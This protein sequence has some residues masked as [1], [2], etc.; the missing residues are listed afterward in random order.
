[1]P[2]IDLHKTARQ[3]CAVCSVLY[4]GLSSYLSKFP[5]GQESERSTDENANI[6]L[7]ATIPLGAG[8]SN[9]N[10]QAL[11]PSGHTICFDFFKTQDSGTS[12]FKL[13]SILILLQASCVFVSHQA[14]SSKDFK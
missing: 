12:T 2:L 14:L 9:Y 4:E 1:M 11:M 5:L 7:G 8:I 13:Y 3:G 6:I 10:Y